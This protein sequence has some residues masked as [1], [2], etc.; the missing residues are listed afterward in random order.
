VLNVFVHIVNVSIHSLQ[1]DEA[2]YDDIAWVDANVICGSEGSVNG[3]P[4]SFHPAL[5]KATNDYLSLLLWK[6]IETAATDDTPE[7]KLRQL[8]QQ[9]I[10]LKNK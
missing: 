5:Q 4:V 10:A 9:F 8:V 2:E 1:M 3:A 6:Q 7:P